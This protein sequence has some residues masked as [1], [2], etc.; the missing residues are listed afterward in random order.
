VKSGLLENERVAKRGIV[1]LNREFYKYPPS[2][3]ITRGNETEF[4]PIFT[5]KGRGWPEDGI[6]VST[7][8][9][10]DQ[11][12]FLPYDQ[13]AVLEAPLMTLPQFS[14]VIFTSP[15]TFLC[16]KHI[17]VPLQISDGTIVRFSGNGADIQ[18]FSDAAEFIRGKRVY[19]KPTNASQG[20]GLL[21]IDAT[22]K[23]KTVFR[24][25]DEAFLEFIAGEFGPEHMYRGEVDRWF[26]ARL[27]NAAARWITRI[28]QD[29]GYEA[30]STDYLFEKDKDLLLLEGKKVEIRTLLQ[31]LGGSFAITGHYAK[32][33][34]GDVIANR[35]EGATSAKSADA[36]EALSK[37]H[38]LQLS[39]EGIESKISSIAEGI[40]RRYFEIIKDPADHLSRY[41]SIDPQDAGRYVPKDRF[42]V[43]LFSIDFGMCQSEGHIEPVVIEINPTS[44]IGIDGLYEAEP[45]IHK[46]VLD[47]HVNNMGLLYATTNC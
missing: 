8:L 41:F 27:H 47:K 26:V 7:P 33:G 16:S 11:E 10:P 21:R 5:Y 22:E 6:M 42:A 18:G 14:R 4:V 37:E 15:P 17:H 46:A 32:I 40:I 1:V 23:G 12:G 35:G 9:Q 36:L 43:T 20:Y 28:K 19:A 25:E 24:S 38:G 45:H 34:S 31:N 3:N 13:I 44:G 30:F 2:F 39:L 29:R